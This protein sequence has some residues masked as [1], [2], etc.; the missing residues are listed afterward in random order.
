MVNYISVHHTAVKDTGADQTW[1]VNQ[2]HK[3]KWNFKSTL[4]YYG[5]YNYFMNSKGKITQFRA[6]GEETAA[7]VGHNHDTISICL[8]GDFNVHM[9]SEAQNASLRGF[10]AQMR[11]KYPNAEIKLH[12]EL[13]TNRTCPGAL[14]TREYLNSLLEGET[15]DERKAK[16]IKRLMG[17]VARLRATIERLLVNRK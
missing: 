16:E 15:E 6:D 11:E 5:G 1:A 7:Q 10:L 17:I 2:Y 12:R 3:D 14:F 9:P 4:G 8:Q 13:Q